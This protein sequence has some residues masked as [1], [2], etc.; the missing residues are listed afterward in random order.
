MP[1]CASNSHCRLARALALGCALAAT[2]ARAD[3]NIT[4]VQ[5]DIANNSVRFSAVVATELT[6]PVVEAINKGIPIEFIIDVMLEEHRRI[7]WD[8]ELH[9]WDLRR[10]VQYHA[11]AKQFMVHGFG[12]ASE[13]FESLDAALKYLGT[14]KDIKLLVPERL[15]KK[16]D[17]R[18][19]LR[20]RLDIETLPPPLRPLAYTS[21]AWR[22]N[23]GWRKWKVGY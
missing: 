3:F 14:L 17:Y 4:M 2:A 11:L 1:A 23:S 16:G 18:L 15:H 5:S 10:R 20:T 9:T 8:P 21:G 6:A 22:L 7:W 19:Y 13:G 12:L